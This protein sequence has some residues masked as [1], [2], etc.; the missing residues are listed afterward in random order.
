[1]RE[2]GNFWRQIK[3]NEQLPQSTTS[4]ESE[5]RCCLDRLKR[6]VQELLSIREEGGSSFVPQSKKE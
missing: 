3:K 6:Y 4:M 5:M 1:M 2:I